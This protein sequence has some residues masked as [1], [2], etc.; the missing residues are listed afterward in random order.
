MTNKTALRPSDPIDVLG[1]SVRIYNGLQRHE[2]HTV[3]DLLAR[4]RW[5]LEDIRNFGAAALK[6]IT[7]TLAARGLAL[8]EPA[9]TGPSA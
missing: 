2:I 7:D 4:E 8:A 9:S 6:E 3:G 5:E 1:F